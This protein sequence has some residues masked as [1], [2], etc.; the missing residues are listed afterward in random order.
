[1]VIPVGALGEPLFGPPP[2]ELR[3]RFQVIKYCVF[4]MMAALMVRLMSG[5]LMDRVYGMFVSSFNLILNTVVGIF[6]LSD[7]EHLGPVYKFMI[8]TC[9]S[10][11]SEQCRGGMS[12]LMTFV[13]CNLITVVMEVLLNRTIEMI[14]KGFEVVF[15]YGV[16]TSTTKAAFLLYLISVTLAFVAQ[17]IGSWHGWKAHQEAQAIGTTVV[18]GTWN[19]AQPASG[20]GGGWNDW[21]GGQLGSGGGGQANQV[22]MQDRPAQGGQAGPAAPF[23]AFSGQGNRLGE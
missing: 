23:Q 15:T 16:N 21:G 22:E 2:P 17:S 19:A 6:L 13:L 5:M 10:S 4:T 14:L 11:C 18:P 3:H 1:M 7:D 9:C 8:T 20:G 12:C